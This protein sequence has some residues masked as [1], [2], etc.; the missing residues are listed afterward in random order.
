MVIIRD[1]GQKWVIIQ[2]PFCLRTG[3]S[4]WIPGHNGKKCRKVTY[5]IDDQN[6]THAIIRISFKKFMTF[7]KIYF[8]RTMCKT[9]FLSF[10]WVWDLNLSVLKSK[11]R[12]KGIYSPL[13]NISLCK[14]KLNR[15]WNR[16]IFNLLNVAEVGMSDFRQKIKRFEHH[17]NN[18]NGR[19]SDNRVLILT[20]NTVYQT[21]YSL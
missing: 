18:R 8:C 21:Y 3:S 7:I 12:K 15:T 4:A 5:Q 9:D 1:S 20:R 2:E 16:R 6:R 14:I 11:T 13:R 17:L 19:L 10:W